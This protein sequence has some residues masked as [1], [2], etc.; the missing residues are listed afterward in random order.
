MAVNPASGSSPQNT[1]VRTPTDTT[2]PKPPAQETPGPSNKKSGPYNN[3][4][5]AKATTNL[6][7]ACPTPAGGAP[8][9]SARMRFEE[10]PPKLQETLKKSFAHPDQ[11]WAGLGDAQRQTLA[12]TFNR[13]DSMGLWKHVTK[14]TG[15][16]GQPEAPVGGKVKVAGHAGGISFETDDW[17]AFTNDLKNTHK[18]GKD[19]DYVGALHPG[20]I[21]LRENNPT[22]SSLHIAVGPGNH[23]DA[24]VDKYSPVDTPSPTGGT[25]L[26]PQRSLEHHSKEVWPGKIRQR[27]G[28]PGVFVGV[29][30]DLADVTRSRTPADSKTPGP[31]NLSKNPVLGSLNLIFQLA[32]KEIRIQHPREKDTASVDAKV[33][34]R[35]ETAGAAAATADDL[36]NKAIKPDNPLYSNSADPAALASSIAGHIANAAR[37]GRSTAEIKLPPYYD[38]LPAPERKRIAAAIANIAQAVAARLPEDMQGVRSLKI[39][40]GNRSEYVPLSK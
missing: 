24:H 20:Q 15:E 8:V 16:K 23:F 6:P 4:D 33:I 30:P 2:N 40:F 1:P 22:E 25:T 27:T 26:D 35:A 28:I 12:T 37:D 11:F 21:S 29:G 36:R 9:A 19:P 13:L 34:K 14:I 38:N 10:L 3:D 39:T 17:K 32:D 7:Q 5:L 31:P 18:F